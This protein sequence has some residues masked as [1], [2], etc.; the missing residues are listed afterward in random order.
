MNDENQTNNKKGSRKKR[1]YARKLKFESITPEQLQQVHTES[2][3]IRLLGMNP[4]N[5]SHRKYV[6]KLIKE[7]KLLE[8]PTGERERMARICDYCFPSS[9]PRS[10]VGV[11]TK[12]IEKKKES[13]TFTY[14][15][16]KVS[17]E[18]VIFKTSKFEITIEDPSV[19]TLK[20]II[21]SLLK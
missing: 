17:V 1:A 14:V 12:P 2:D 4:K 11:I 8:Y 20:A 10:H 3:L 5:S 15:P 18:K 21:E 19:F 7:K 9:D 13:R 6:K 16:K